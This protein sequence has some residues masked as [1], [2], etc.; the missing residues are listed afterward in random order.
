MVPE[1]AVAMLAC[2]R[3]GA[4][5]SVVFGGFSPEA[6]AGRIKDCDS[7]IVV[8]ADEGLR[9]GKISAFCQR[10]T[11]EPGYGF[12]P[13]LRFGPGPIQDKVLFG[14]TWNMLNLPMQQIF[15][16][17]RELPGVT[18]PLADKWLGG[19]ARKVFQLG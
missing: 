4:I 13:L 11:A 7:T 6:L 3:I 5:H 14:S 17:V 16:E 9:G 1:A 10:N 15:Q 19:N 12:E 18:P 2:A 8:T